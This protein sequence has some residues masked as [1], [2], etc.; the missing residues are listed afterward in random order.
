MCVCTVNFIPWHGDSS[1]DFEA[2]DIKQDP[3][4]M[5]LQGSEQFSHLKQ[6][7]LRCPHRSCGGRGIFCFIGELRE[8]GHLGPHPAIWCFGFGLPSATYWPIVW[9]KA[10]SP[11]GIGQEFEWLPIATHSQ[12]TYIY[13]GIIIYICIII[14]IY[15]LSYIYICIIIS[16]YVLSYLYI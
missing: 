11:T 12:Y 15:V 1:C 3:T 5:S 10:L 13:V 14:Y 16:I 6:S 2:S 8:L 7:R 9:G 4:S